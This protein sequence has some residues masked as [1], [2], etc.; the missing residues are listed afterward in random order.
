MDR[1]GEQPVYVGVRTGRTFQQRS[2][3][4]FTG[5]NRNLV[6]RKEGLPRQNSKGTSTQKFAPEA[7]AHGPVKLKFLVT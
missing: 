6:Q 7:T 5:K 1:G 2:C 3:L 4:S